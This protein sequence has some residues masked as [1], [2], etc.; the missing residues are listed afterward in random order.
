[1]DRPMA[2]HPLRMNNST[3]KSDNTLLMICY[4]RTLIAFALITLP[5]LMPHPMTG[6][7]LSRVCQLQK[8]PIHDHTRSQQQV[9]W[10]GSSKSR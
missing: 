7:S 10:G 6:R 2:R 9:Q 3:F 1:M 4:N 8:R 5:R